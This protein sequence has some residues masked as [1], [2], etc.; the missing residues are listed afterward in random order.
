MSVNGIGAMGYPMAAYQNRRANSIM[1]EGAF[2][3]RMEQVQK[4]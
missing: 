1:A 3:G 2:A 4:S